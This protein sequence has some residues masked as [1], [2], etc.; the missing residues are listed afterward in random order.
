MTFGHNVNFCFQCGTC[1]QCHGDN[2]A[3]SVLSTVGVGPKYERPH[4]KC[5][6]RNGRTT[7]THPSQESTSWQGSRTSRRRDK[8]MRPFLQSPCLTVVCSTLLLCI[9]QQQQQHVD[10]R[11]ILLGFVYPLVSCPYGVGIHQVG[12]NMASTKNVA[13]RNGHGAR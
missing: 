2:F 6:C 13:P 10:D 4:R 12:P 5:Q 7:D 8:M 9:A 3:L 1:A 11:S